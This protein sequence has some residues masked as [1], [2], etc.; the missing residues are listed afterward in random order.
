MKWN[1]HAWIYVIHHTIL[2]MV[3][4][5]RMIICMV[6]SPW[7]LVYH[8]HRC[9]EFYNN[10]TLVTG[11]KYTLVQCNKFL[12]N[13]INNTLDSYYTSSANSFSCSPCS[14]DLEISINYL[15]VSWVYHT[16]YKMWFVKNSFLSPNLDIVWYNQLTIK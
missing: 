7:V 8:A 10:C 16:I 5:I 6:I 2:P 13:T 4:Y 3:F 12:C 14:F 15:M 9:T 11:E 1:G